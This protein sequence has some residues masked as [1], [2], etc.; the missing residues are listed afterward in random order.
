MNLIN[1]VFEETKQIDFHGELIWVPVN[2]THV[3]MDCDGRIHAFPASPTIN[4]AFLEFSCKYYR[5]VY[6]G[7]MF[8]SWNKLKR[9]GRNETT[10]FGMYPDWRLSVVEY[11]TT[12]EGESK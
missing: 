8:N 6:V 4:E 11:P 9:N 3:A 1:A 5:S 7:A 2:T 10:S 12:K